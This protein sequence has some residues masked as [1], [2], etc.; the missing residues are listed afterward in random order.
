M[1]QYNFKLYF[2]KLF[3]LILFSIIGCF[4]HVKDV[5]ALEIAAHSYDLVYKNL[6]KELQD[7]DYCYKMDNGQAMLTFATYNGSPYRTTVKKKEGVNE[8]L[9]C[10]NYKRHIE[11]TDSYELK[12][13][14][15]GNGVRTRLGIAFYNGPVKWGQ[16]AKSQFTT[17]NAMLDYY[18]TQ[19]VV[20]SL[21][22]KY[23]GEKSDMG[24]DF[25]KLKFKEN[26]GDL[27]K[28]TKAFYKYCCDAKVQYTNG[29]FQTIKFEFLE[30]DDTNMYVD[31]TYMTSS[32]IKCS[33]NSDNAS[34]AEYTRTATSS[35]VTAK[36][37]IIDSAKDS[38]DSD[39]R[40]K[41]PVSVIEQLEPST[42]SV[43]V[44]EDVKFNRKKA[45]LWQCVAEDYVDTSQEVGALIDEEKSVNDKEQFQFVIGEVYLYKR[46]SITGEDI[47]DA[48]FEVHQ[49]NTSTNQY[50][51]YKKMFFNKETQ[52][53]ESGNLYLS[54]TNK[55][56]LFKVIETKAGDNYYLDWPG[57][58][59]TINSDCYVQEIIA[60][61][62][63]VLGELSITKTGEKWSY[64]DQS[65]CFDK[66]IPLAKVQFELYAKENVYIKDQLLY[67]KD[68]K[69]A[70]IITDADGKGTVKSLPEGKY[71]IKEMRTLQDYI[72]DETLHDFE[73][74]RDSNRKYNK[75]QI[76]IQ[77]KLKTSEISLFKY[78]YNDEDTKQKNPIPLKNA[79]FGLYLKEDLCDAFGNIILK[80]DTCIAKEYTDDKG[81]IVFDGLPYTSFYIK[82]L[83]APKD[84]IINDGIIEINLKDFQFNKEKGVYYVKKDII[85]KQQHFS[86]SITK[87]AEAYT[88][89]LKEN[90]TYGEFYSYQIGEATLQN[91]SFSL[92]NKDKQLLDSKI[93]D[94]KGKVSFENLIPGV[95]YLSETSSPAEY[96][97]VEDEREIVFQM[98]S[99]DYNEF[100]QPVIEEH[101]FNNLCECNINL[102]KLGEQFYI[103]NNALQYRNVPLENVVFGIYQDFDYTFTE[104]DNILPKGTCVGYINTD[105]N[106]VGNFVGKLP[107]GRYYIKEIKTLEGYD[108][109]TNTYHFNIEPNNNQKITV[110]INDESNTFYNKLSKAAVKIIKTD[111]ENHKPL[112]NVEF[113]LFNEYGEQIGIYKTNRKGEILVENLP[114]GTYYFLETKAPKGYYSTNNKFYFKI[115]SPDLRTLNV[116]NSPVIQLGFDESYT[117][118]LY[119]IAIICI[120][121]LLGMMLSFALRKRSNH[122][123]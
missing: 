56:G 59:F 75:A 6:P 88:G 119:G 16:K 46:D 84:F 87:T 57:Y 91:V 8:Y 69:I 30:P 110:R 117:K 27:E 2:I 48:E 79:K 18:M 54:T 62:Q 77:N 109:D 12:Q 49:F 19:I 14:I 22:G 81:M 106:G 118:V 26:T 94:A 61:N 74:V 5:H 76:T 38:Y 55:E 99:K 23:A 120:I 11:F 60:E 83:E 97:K 44:N 41:I 20:H 63:P 35:S 25:S 66:N 92:Y 29:N 32:Q 37:V 122:H 112:K 67:Q 100:S 4:F 65:F 89:Y 53:Y 78:Y 73:I 13:S 33:I 101:Y 114:Y 96:V 108:I 24:I 80:K 28:K 39:F 15:F 70:D 115:D 105:K 95:Y 116:T 36:D 121:I 9:Y 90:S 1:Y 113:T 51:F 104:H 42:Y 82:E 34:V 17:G 93:T 43:S 103:E 86:L 3:T 47:Y 7:S 64:K 85:N 50:E 58:S 10:I 123:E 102:I 40:V 107:C 52:R 31:G 111:A 72:L 71:Y 45:G 68:K 98:D 21:I